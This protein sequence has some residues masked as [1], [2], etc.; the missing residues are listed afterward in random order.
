MAKRRLTKAE[1]DNIAQASFYMGGFGMLG[2]RLTAYI[3]LGDAVSILRQAEEIRKQGNETAD[4]II[5]TYG[6][7]E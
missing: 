2:Y 1:R 7:T 4:W 6:G 3:E 5:K